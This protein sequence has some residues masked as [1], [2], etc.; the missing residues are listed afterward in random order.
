MNQSL[1]NCNTLILECMQFVKCKLIKTLIT[2]PQES[3]GKMN[4]NEQVQDG[5]NDKLVISTACEEPGLGTV[6]MQQSRSLANQFK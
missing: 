3:D 5:R 4:N 1:C 2:A 6:G